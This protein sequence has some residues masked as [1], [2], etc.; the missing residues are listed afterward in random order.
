MA[1]HSYK[2]VQPMGFCK[3][4]VLKSKNVAPRNEIKPVKFAGQAAM[5][6]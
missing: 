6:R 1:M 3:N 4:R 5:N 2:I